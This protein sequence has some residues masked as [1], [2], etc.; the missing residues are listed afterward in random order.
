MKQFWKG[1]NLH[2]YFCAFHQGGRERKR[3]REIESRERKGE[4]NEKERATESEKDLTMN[5][6]KPERYQKLI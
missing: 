4:R 1:G 3:Q 5:K 6:I 2:S